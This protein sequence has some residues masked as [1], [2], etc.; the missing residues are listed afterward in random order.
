MTNR[1]S[2]SQIFTGFSR[3]NPSR[4][5]P[6]KSLTPEFKFRVVKL[7][8]ESFPGYGSLIPRSGWDTNFW[9]EIHRKLSYLLGTENLATKRAFSQGEDAVTFLYECEDDVFL[10]FVEVIFQYSQLWEARDQ[11]NPEELVQTINELLEVDALPYFLTPFAF[12]PSP[13]TPPAGPPRNMIFPNSGPRLNASPQI[14]RRE[15]EVVHNTVTEP[16]LAFLTHPAFGSAN[17]EFL[18]SLADYRKGNYRDCV[19][20]CESAFESVMKVICDLKRWSYS[21]HGEPSALLKTILRQTE[22]APYY[23]K[24]VNLIG[25]VEVIRNEESTAHGAGT[26]PRTIPKQVA[27]F[28]VNSTASAI[29]LLV[30]EINP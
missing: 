1:I 26:Q 22:L 14:I 3:R 4:G 25:L 13:P 18:G 8:Y 24:L 23:Q 9:L 27:S 21:G 12:S 19:T 28:V 6:S 7:C 20:K 2:I 10:H 5:K 15:N 30:E 29:L 17:E 16:T 11:T